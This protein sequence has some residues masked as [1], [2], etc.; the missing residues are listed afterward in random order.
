MSNLASLKLKS[1]QLYFKYKDGVITLEEYQR[2]LRSLDNTI[3]SQ[4]IQ[5]ISDYLQDNL[6]L[7][8]SSLELHG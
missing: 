4:E 8:K 5:T 3:D 1:I 6:V 2:K 7:Q